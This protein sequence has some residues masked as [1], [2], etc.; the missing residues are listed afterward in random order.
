MK[1]SGLCAGVRPHALR[2]GELTRTLSSRFHSFLSRTQV[3]SLLKHK[4]TQRKNLMVFM[5][6]LFCFCRNCIGQNFAMAEI[7]VVVAQT[8]SRFRILP[9]PKPV[10]R[11][12]QLV[13]R[14][15]GGLILNVERLSEWPALKHIPLQ[16]LLWYFLIIY[17]WFKVLKGNCWIANRLFCN[18]YCSNCLNLL[19]FDWKFKNFVA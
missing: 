13:L 1:S 3:R 12:Y 10:R 17:Y 15:E 4:E 2:P 7:K 11:L 9:G 18:I 16:C 14:A 5:L 19:C 8:L 6:L